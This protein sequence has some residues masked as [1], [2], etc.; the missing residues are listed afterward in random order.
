MMSDRYLNFLE[1]TEFSNGLSYSPKFK[2][3]PLN[4]LKALTQITNNKRVLHV[5]CVDHEDIIA[6]KLK[7]NTWLHKLLTE[8]SA[9]CLGIDTNCSGVEYI[10]TLGFSNAICA[11]LD[12][13][14]VSE[15]TKSHWDFML[16]GEILEHVGNPVNFLSSI[17]NNY[18]NN[19]SRIIITVPNAFRF[20]N[21]K[22]ALM[23]IERINTDHRFWF[24]P[25][26]LSKLLVLSGFSIEY[27]SMVNCFE[28][29][30]G[31]I[32]K[33]PLEYIL[34]KNFPLLRGDIFLVATFA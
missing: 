21:F 4:R 30:S 10:K 2:E 18:K 24:T 34:H 25:Y 17:N 7:T 15:V 33:R 16:L 12:S 13:S 31:R 22:R 27:I 9:E 11:S 32:I 19:V 5:G 20:I 26:T 6:K 14:P 23:G 29:S 3:L 8:V 1:G 28:Y